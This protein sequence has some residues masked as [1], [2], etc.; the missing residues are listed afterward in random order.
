MSHFSVMVVGENPE[1]QLAYFDESLQVEEYEVGIVSKEQKDRM[2]A[3]YAENGQVF[4]SFDECYAECGEEW[5]GNSYRKD[6]DGIWREYSTNNPDAKWDWYV[7]GGRWSG[8][9][10]RLKPGATSGVYGEPSSFGNE[11][12]IDS[13][14]KGDID[15]VAF[16]REIEEKARQ[17]Y[18]E[19]VAKCGGSIP[20]LELTWETIWNGSEYANL[21][22]AEKQKL[23]HNQPAV[24]RWEQT[25]L[26]ESFFGPSLQNF[27]C[28]EDEFVS[29]S[30]LKAFA[31][32]AFVKNGVWYGSGDMG[33]FGVSTN[34]KPPQEWQLEVL[35]MVESLPDDT[36]ISFYDCHI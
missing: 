5:N 19:V 12:G 25:G 15:F 4:S 18:R 31:P 1:E 24:K 34:Q 36:L 32:Y 29:R 3:F 35:K 20:K 26:D 22:I 2:L 23:Y 11:V 27:Q 16:R 13:A 21:S 14:R 6:E 10:I 28:T 8:C 30:V 17:C 33:W 9:Y 7:L